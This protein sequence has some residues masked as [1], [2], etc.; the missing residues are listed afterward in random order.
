[1]CPWRQAWLRITLFSGTYTQGLHLQQID[2]VSELPQSLPLWLTEV[3]R[4]STYRKW[5][6]PYDIESTL[7]C[8]HPKQ[9]L[10]HTENHHYPED[11]HFQILHY[12]IHMYIPLQFQK[13]TNLMEIN[14]VMSKCW[15]EET[16]KPQYKQ[17]SKESRS[18]KSCFSLSCFLKT[19]WQRETFQ[20]YLTQNSLSR[21][22]IYTTNCMTSSQ[23]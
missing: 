8:H 5:L 10:C 18:C 23:H 1:M 12:S 9:R 7:Q 13:E 3:P 15:E 6:L 11:K 22:S 20:L 4:W 17:W 2:K 19:S 21:H 16:K 14:L